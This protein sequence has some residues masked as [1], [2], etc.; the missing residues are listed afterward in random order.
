LIYGYFGKSE[1]FDDAIVKFAQAYAEQN[2]ADWDVLN[3]A[4]KA[5]RIRAVRE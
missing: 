1:A 5:G 3:K 2:E 4:A